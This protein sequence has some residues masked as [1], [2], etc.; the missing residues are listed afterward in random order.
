MLVDTFVVGS[1]CISS[2]LLTLCGS[3]AV[4]MPLRMT[5]EF[6]LLVHRKS[7]K[8]SNV[9]TFNPIARLTR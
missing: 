9:S 7:S 3:K 8:S 5:R 6:F 4:R 2:V 1:N